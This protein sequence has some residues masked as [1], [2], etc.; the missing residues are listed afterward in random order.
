M[1]YRAIACPPEL[2][3]QRGSGVREPLGRAVTYQARGYSASIMQMAS[4]LRPILWS[5]S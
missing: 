5:T 3:R 1:S 4:G 2:H